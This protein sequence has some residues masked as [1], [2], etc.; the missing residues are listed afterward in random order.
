MAR[1]PSDGRTLAERVEVI[2]E[3]IA[4]ATR[5]DGYLEG[6][7]NLSYMTGIP[8][9]ALNTNLMALATAKCSEMYPGYT[10]MVEKNWGSYYLAEV[11]SPTNIR[12]SAGECRAMSTKAFRT[13]H[14][15]GDLANSGALQQDIAKQAL[16]WSKK[17]T[18]NA[19]GLEKF[20]ALLDQQAVEV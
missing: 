6:Q 15:L 14:V 7:A 11:A 9:S 20:A 13:G 4:E 18:K 10:I 17:L 16:T 5:T 1:K 3:T 8:L 19:L 12:W 2:V